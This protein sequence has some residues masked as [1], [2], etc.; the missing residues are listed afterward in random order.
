MSAYAWMNGMQAAPGG[1]RGDTMRAEI[2]SD[3]LLVASARDRGRGNYPFYTERWMGDL[4]DREEAYDGAMVAGQRK[5]PGP[6]E[7]NSAGCTARVVV[8]AQLTRRQRTVV[9]WLAQG[10]SQGQIAE[11]LGVSEASVTRLK[12]AAFDQMR[13]STQS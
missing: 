10:L 2:E 1:A 12:Q 3:Q 4:S 8:D 9:R 11:M 5:P 13:A 6:G 7:G